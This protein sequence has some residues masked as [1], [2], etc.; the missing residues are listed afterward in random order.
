MFC[1]LEFAK[2]N[3]IL[4][5]QREYKD[6]FIYDLIYSNFDSV[7]DILSRGEIWG[8]NLNQPHV[9]I[10]FNAEEYQDFTSDRHLI[11]II[12][13]IVE[14]ELEKITEKPI[15]M[16]K[17]GQIISIVPVSKNLSLK[18]NKTSIKK[19]AEKTLSA[20]S[21]R[22][23]NRKIGIGIGR[24]YSSPSDIFRSFQESKVALELGRLIEKQSRI[25]FFAD[26]GFIRI[27]YSH[28][29]QEL[30]EFYS[31][32]LGELDCPDN[33]Q[34]KELMKTLEEYIHHQFDLKSTAQSM[35]LHPNTLRYRLKKSKMYWRSI[36][37][38]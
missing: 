27:L 19:W 7:K 30:R 18:E 1:A 38:N 3:S 14:A 13:Q 5:A 36:S 9:V 15:L 12:Y 22:V 24:M 37:M 32:T 31:E 10:V 29:Q 25:Y 23:V 4:K 21:V 6:A 28:D 20:M 16:R 8:W 33:D 11:E 34:D 26:L 35:F 17:Q 2:N